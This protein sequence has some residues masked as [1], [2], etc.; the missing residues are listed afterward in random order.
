MKQ[1]V[2]SVAHLLSSLEFY[3]ISL[4]IDRLSEPTTSS[5]WSKH[6]VGYH[7]YI[8]STRHDVRDKVYSNFMVG[9]KSTRLRLVL[10]DKLGVYSGDIG[11]I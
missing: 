7:G 3:L 9:I 8:K 1:I 10:V 4:G 2:W 5:S 11:F 6:V